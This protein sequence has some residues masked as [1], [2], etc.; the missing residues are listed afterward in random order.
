MSYIAKIGTV[1]IQ[2]N[3]DKPIP[4]G[5]VDIGDLIPKNP[6]WDGKTVREKNDTEL[7][8]DATNAVIKQKREAIKAQ[9]VNTIVD[10]ILAGKIPSDPV[11]ADVAAKVASA[12]A[13]VAAISDIQAV[14]P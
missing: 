6:I 11:M 9:V 7:A 5:Y 1:E 3:H 2:W 13:A 10:S 4:D 12:D 14:K 8:Q